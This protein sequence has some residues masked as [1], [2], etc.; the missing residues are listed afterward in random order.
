MG[1]LPDCTA[2]EHLSLYHCDVEDT[3]VDT[4][5]LILPVCY[6]LRELDLRMNSLTPAVHAKLRTTWAQVSER[7]PQG[8][9]L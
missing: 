4:L 2:L 9:L 1:V 5:M 6:A 8:L 7:E 3:W